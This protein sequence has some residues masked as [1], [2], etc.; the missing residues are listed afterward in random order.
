[1]VNADRVAAL[2][3]DVRELIPV[4]TYGLYELVWTLNGQ[5]PELD[6]TAKIE[7]AMAAVEQLVREDDLRI[8]MLNWPSSEIVREIR[9]SDVGP[10]DFE[11]P[12]EGAPY[13]ALASRDA[14]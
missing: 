10:S 4:G 7:D 9:L 6:R 1:M 2:V 8:V 13:A 14:T 11:N 3:E 5:Y 12:P